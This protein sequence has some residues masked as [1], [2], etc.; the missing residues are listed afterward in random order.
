MTD[1]AGRREELQRKGCPHPHGDP[2][3]TCPPGVFYCARQGVCRRE[4]AA[5]GQGAR[6]A[7]LGCA[8]SVNPHQ[9]GRE[10]A[11]PSLRR[12]WQ[13]GFDSVRHP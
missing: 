9:H 6:A 4:A 1:K 5:Y 12:H 13:L 8:A 7:R 2:Q 11:D 10:H 3:R